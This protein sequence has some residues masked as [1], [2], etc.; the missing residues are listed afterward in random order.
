LPKT[1]KNKLLIIGGTA[2]GTAAAAKAK[3]V[4]PGLDITLFE[5][6]E[7]ISYSTCSM[8]Y[9]VGNVIP[10]YKDLISYSPDRFEKEKGCT[11]KVFHRV[12]NIIPARKKII[13][14]E[15][16]TDA[17]QEYHYDR[18]L[19]AS[20]ARAKIPNSEWLKAKNVFTVKNL[21]DSIQLKHFIDSMR[22]RSAL[23]IGGGFIGME[24]AEAL[25]QH[26]IDIKILHKSPL[27]MNTLEHESQKIIRDEL[28]RHG[29]SFI[30][31]TVVTDIR[32]DHDAVTS[33]QTGDGDFS[34]DMI[35]LALGFEPNLDF[36]R[37]AKIRRGPFGGI[38]VDAKM[39][40]NIEHIYAAGAC[41]E[42]RNLVSNKSMYLPL[43]NIANK[44]GW[45]AG[46]NIAGGSA[47]FLGAVRT[48]AV[49]IFDL[50]V[51][52]V[53]LSSHE[54][55][56]CGFKVITDGINAYSR[57]KEFPGSKPIFVKFII[58]QLSKRLLGANLI[59]EEGAALRANT[60]SAAI[61]NKM[62]IRQIA[63][64]DFMYTPPYSPVWDPILVA[65]NQSLKK[66]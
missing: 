48:T 35:L 53:G 16:K 57:I 62:T 54:A 25:A 5:Q 63:D 31:E 60:L 22:P 20:G 59:G 49:K 52:S 10:N 6:G 29:V 61:Q 9:F 17:A 4:N 39:R 45:V 2:A 40:T 66:L 1:P 44:M 64:L 55:G 32:M 38:L 37:D 36:A 13:V 58:D 8:P 33:V 12:E 21:S 46:E 27:P 23:I 50:E 51:A 30:G 43:G 11:V 65:A 18:L 15:L 28:K 56:L 7:F 42:I 26:R 47:Q 19:I 3:R 14:R 41:T 34:A 24:M